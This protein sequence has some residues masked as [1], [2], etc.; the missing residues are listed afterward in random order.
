MTFKYPKS[1]Q[2]TLVVTLD[3]SAAFDRADINA[4]IYKLASC[5]QKSYMQKWLEN[6]MKGRTF[7]VWVQNKPSTIHS[8]ISS[9]PQGSLLAS[10]LFNVLLR[11]PPFTKASIMI[12]ADDNTLSITSKTKDEAIKIMQESPDSIAKYVHSLGPENKPSE[13]N[14][15]FLHKK[16]SGTSK[17]KN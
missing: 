8:I 10:I 1:H 17:A 6:Y 9:V 2:I 7:R 4:I 15:D 16:T 5:G 13:V 3:L 12:Y 11:D 14:N